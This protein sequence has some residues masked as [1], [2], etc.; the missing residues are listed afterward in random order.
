MNTNHNN[1]GHRG[2]YIPATQ[3]TALCQPREPLCFVGSHLPRCQVSV[4]TLMTHQVTPLSVKLVACS[5]LMSN[6]PIAL[7]CLEPRLNR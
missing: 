1:G 6:F 7:D 4:E 2:D 3:C 5:L